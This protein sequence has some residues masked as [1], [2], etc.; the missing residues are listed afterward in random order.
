MRLLPRRFR[1]RL[2]LAVAA[3]L[4]VS[5]GLVFG[6][7]QEISLARMRAG[8]EERFQRTLSAFHALEALRARALADEIES[9]AEGNPQFRT[10]L[11]TASLA[12]ADLGFGEPA[13]PDPLR[14]ANA[15]L[16]SLLPWLPL[17]RRSDVF[18]VLSASGQL[19]YSK[20]DPERFG[21]RLE[22]LDAF[23]AAVSRGT[24][25]E[26]WS[27]ASAPESYA[28]LVPADDAAPAYQV[29]GAPVLFEQEIHGVVIAGT[30]LDR[31]ALASIADVSGVALALYAGE[32]LL[33]STLPR[34]DE[35]ALAG[36]V[37]A[38]AGGASQLATGGRRWLAQRAPIAAGDDPSEAAFLV[39]A[40][41]DAE[42]A[43]LARL[44]L[45]F[46]AIGGA[47]LLVA[48]VTT[49]LLA[50]GITRPLAA[51]G[52]AAR[53]IGRGDFGVRVSDA[54][55]DELAALGRA[56]NAMAEGL[57]ERE[58]TKRA[59]ERYVSK[60]VAAEILA[61]PTAVQRAGVRRELSVLFA[62]LGGFTA[63]AESL[64]PERV[65]AHLNEYFEAAC[66][67]VLAQ[68]GTVKEFVGDGL[69]AFWGA[70]LPQP[71]HARR[72]CLA[73]LDARDRL[74]RLRASWAERGAP[75]PSFR[76]AVHT[77]ELVVGEI[78]T[79]ERVTY[80]AVG[81]AMNLASRLEGANKFYGTEILISEA[82]RAAA[83]PEV[84]ARE[85]DQVRVVGRRQ[86]VR[87]FEL[88]GRKG[89]VDG[90]T[91]ERLVRFAEG[92]AAL[93]ARDFARAARAFTRDPDDG[94]SRALLRRAESFAASAPP[95]DWDGVHAL[96]EK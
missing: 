28:R 43:D 62:D 89:E 63:L 87:I 39:L 64:A 66:A 77:G 82:T 46:L 83:G 68:D 10:V 1:A 38:G 3:L 49:A 70:P 91:L 45:L 40:S 81:D 7:L 69:V 65:V 35:V 88:V 24:A 52:S 22:N 80:G 34:E 32:R 36:H 37:R 71:D 73:A 94:P 11:S 18:L 59:L 2:F 75:A 96:E 23:V 21:E 8:F 4:C 29:L 61:N 50:R 19:L 78:G 79:A 53:R 85:V 44:R 56:F 33:A 95:P 74:S 9:L 12:E 86:P 58:V 55:A 30:R 54:G 25:L 20:A 15:R 6:V 27:A 67:A 92:L 26:V 42:L 93:R 14:D 84:I 76:L 72:A 16:R 5:L 60:P 13:A 47:I 90:A 17:C 41:I 51:L 31:A 57:A 48:L